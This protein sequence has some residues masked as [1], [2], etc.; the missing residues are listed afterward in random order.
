MTILL[1]S[2]QE[3][4]ACLLHPWLREE[5][6]VKAEGTHKCNKMGWKSIFL[7]HYGKPHY[8]KLLKQKEKDAME[9]KAS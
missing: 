7:R 2:V 1:C 6:K 3:S 8:E 4:D 5:H 9:R